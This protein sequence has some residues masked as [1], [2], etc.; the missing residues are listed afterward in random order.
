LLQVRLDDTTIAAP[1][2]GYVIERHVEPGE[3]VRPG[4]P[5]ITL[6]SAGIIEA[7][8]EVPERFAGDIAQATTPITV[9]VGHNGDM[10]RAKAL[11]AAVSRLQGD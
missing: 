5:I 1:F 11:G 4:D 6:V 10:G 8:I 2:D 9:E 7:W 3:W